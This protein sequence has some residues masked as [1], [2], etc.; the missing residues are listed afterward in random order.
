MCNRNDAKIYE[1]TK[2]P[3]IGKFNSWLLAK[4]EDDFHQETGPMKAQKMQNLSGDVLELGPGNGINFRYYPAGVN[5]IAVEPNPAM[6]QRLQVSA[7]NSLANVEIKQ[8][9]LENLALADNSVDAVV[10]TLVLCTVPDPEKIL[11]EVLRIL[12]P[13]GQ[14]IFVEHVGA[15]S[16]SMKRKVQNVLFKPWKYL[17]EGCCTNRDTTNL[18]QSVGFSKI[19]VEAFES[20]A[21]PAPI[22]PNIVGVATK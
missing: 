18:L 16:G 3:L 19:N 5:L 8:D 15:P 11:Q 12:K 9:L 6:Y 10:C 1:F 13:G 17:F 21:M 14:Y 2:H 7:N 20:Q 4:F 22:S